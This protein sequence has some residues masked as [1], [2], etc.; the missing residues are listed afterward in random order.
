MTV[1]RRVP[2]A[3]LPPAPEQLE[4]FRR[5]KAQVDH[6]LELRRQARTAAID[7]AQQPAPVDQEAGRG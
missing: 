4:A 2:E 5:V 1:D 6:A 7:Q 3:S